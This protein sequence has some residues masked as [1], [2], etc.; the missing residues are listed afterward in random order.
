VVAQIARMTPR[1]HLC[2][3]SPSMRGCHSMEIV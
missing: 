3:R 2:A 1:N